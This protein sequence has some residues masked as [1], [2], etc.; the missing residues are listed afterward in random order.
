MKNVQ[1]ITETKHCLL[2]WAHFTC[3]RQGHSYEKKV[4]TMISTK[5]LTTSYF[6]PPNTKIKTVIYTVLTSRSWLG[7]DTKM[8]QNLT[9]VTIS[10]NPILNNL[11]IKNSTFRSESGK[12]PQKWKQKVAYNITLCWCTTQIVYPHSFNEDNWTINHALCSYE[13]LF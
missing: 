13:I 3:Y 11:I 2:S 7:T 9:M 1:H 6:K 10:C 4:S 12:N 5:W 8:W